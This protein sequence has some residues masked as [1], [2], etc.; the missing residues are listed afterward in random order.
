MAC[1][2]PGS[3]SLSLSLCLSLCVSVCV[4]SHAS[5]GPQRTAETGDMHGWLVDWLLGL[6]CHV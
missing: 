6:W 2:G 4:R 1:Q 5:S 3:P